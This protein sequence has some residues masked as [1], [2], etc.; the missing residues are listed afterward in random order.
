M[1]CCMSPLVP[2]PERTPSMG[3]ERTTVLR[4]FLLSVY[5]GPAVAYFPIRRR[6]HRHSSLSSTSEVTA[7]FQGEDDGSP[8]TVVLSNPA[9]RQD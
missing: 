3:P 2:C 7:L 8:G 1:C 5:M 6:C 9:V 4:W